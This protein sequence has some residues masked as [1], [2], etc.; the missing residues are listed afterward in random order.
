MDPGRIT[1]TP[2]QTE[3]LD[4]IAQGKTNGEIAAVLGITVDGVKF[5][6]SE[7]LNKLGASSREEAAAYWQDHRPTPTRRLMGALAVLATGRGA[8][9]AAMMVVAAGVGALAFAV[10]A[11]QGDAG[12]DPDGADAESHSTA[13]AVAS[14]IPDPTQLPLTDIATLAEMLRDSAVGSVVEAFGSGDVDRVVGV[15]D[16]RPYLC[17]EGQTNGGHGGAVPLCSAEGVPP[18]SEV[19]VVESHDGVLWLMSERWLR[20]ALDVLLRDGNSTSLE[21]IAIGWDGNYL[22]VYSLAEGRAL[23]EELRHGED[24]QGWIVVT[25][26]ASGSRPVISVVLSPADQTPLRLLNLSFEPPTVLAISDAFLEFEAEM[27]RQF[28]EAVEAFA[29]TVAARMTEA[30]S[31]GN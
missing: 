31:T 2:R 30:A 14:P 26:R 29:P 5:H 20:S 11:R 4:L 7:I 25:V 3:V 23:P 13:T 24:P 16:W 22:L 28:E 10:M 27:A 1:W 17:S 9:I 18:G 19:P 6:V 15:I 12:I 8:A 21:L